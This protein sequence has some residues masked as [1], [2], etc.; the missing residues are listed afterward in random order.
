[1]TFSG[2]ILSLNFSN[3]SSYDFSNTHRRNPSDSYFILKIDFCFKLYDAVFY[4]LLLYHKFGNMVFFG[5][6]HL[7]SH[8][9]PGN[10]N[11]QK[12]IYFLIFSSQKAEIADQ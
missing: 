5:K 1:M 3:T 6:A 4:C 12:I 7:Y 8:C 11:Y 2:G 9:S 10:Q